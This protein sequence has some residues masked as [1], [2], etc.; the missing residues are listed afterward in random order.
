MCCWIDDA[1][2]CRLADFGV[3]GWMVRASGQRANVHTFVGTPCWMAP[4]VMEQVDGYN[5]K[6]DIWSLGIT[7]LE[8]AKGYAPYAHYPPMKVLIMTIEQEPP[9]LKN[10]PDDKQCNGQSFSRSFDDFVRKC[11]HKDPMRRADS[12]HLL[13]HKFL[14]N[15]SPAALVDELL[16]KIDS[17]GVG[18]HQETARP[19]GYVD[20]D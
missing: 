6:A 1:I 9:S 3:A 20:K 11:L 15:R 18:E 17:V 16:S 7:A 8:L 10:Y 4:E 19:E 2:A 5:E 13:A 12:E 14:K